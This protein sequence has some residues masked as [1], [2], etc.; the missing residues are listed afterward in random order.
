EAADA[1]TGWYNPAGLAL[2]RQQQVVVGA[3]GVFPSSEL[4]GTS[5]FCVQG[6][7]PR[8]GNSTCHHRNDS[9]ADDCSHGFLH[10]LHS[11]LLN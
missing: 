8:V 11:T 9:C 6:K 4:T 5:T 7:A 10:A 3:V 1:S 2:I